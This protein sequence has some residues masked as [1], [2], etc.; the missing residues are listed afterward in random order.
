M[1]KKNSTTRSGFEYQLEE[2]A[3]SN[4]E[5]LEIIDEIEDNPQRVVKL[6]KLL[7]GNEQYKELKE[8]CKIDGIVD[9]TMM[10][11][12]LVDIMNNSQVKN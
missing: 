8:H 1:E 5:V 7:L 9:A 3:L 12:A 2:K 4:W 11:D 6:A 10:N